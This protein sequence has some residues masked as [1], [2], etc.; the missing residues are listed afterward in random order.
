MIASSRVR[1]PEDAASSACAELVGMSSER[2]MSPA[3]FG[4]RSPFSSV[5]GR[6]PNY[7]LRV[8]PCNS[9]DATAVITN[10]RRSRPRACGPLPVPVCIHAASP[11]N[12]RASSREYSAQSKPEQRTAAGRLCGSCVGFGVGRT[13]AVCC[14]CG[15]GY[16][17]SGGYECETAMTCGSRDELGLISGTPDSCSSHQY[18][19]DGQAMRRRVYSWRP[20]FSVERA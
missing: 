15:I 3:T 4:F 12:C 10:F 8:L 20:R 14:A 19:V 7:S 18:S 11:Q 2:R 6:P 5:P 17:S 13:V 9:P 1:F 16:S